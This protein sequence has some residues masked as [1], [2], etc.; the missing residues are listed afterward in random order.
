MTSLQDIKNKVKLFIWDFHGTLEYGNDHAVHEIT[1]LALEQHGYERRMSMA[2]ALFLSGRLWHEYFEHLLPDLDHDSYVTL[3]NTCFSISQH[4]PEIIAKY[5]SLTPNALEVLDRIDQS[6]HSQ[7]VLSNTR[8]QSLDM[9]LQAVNIQHYFPNPH[10]IAAD[11]LSQD[12]LTKK[13]Y[14]SHFL[15]DKIFPGGIVAIGDSIGDVELAECHPA[16][17]GY[18]FSHPDRPH[19]SPTF[20]NKINNLLEILKEI[21]NGL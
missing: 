15:K 17:I 8:P 7:I 12:K 13:D 3:Q 6:P 18:L 21:W 16:G 9:F 20:Q 19:R 10:R 1:N 5:I 4:Q 11:S 2:E 14:L